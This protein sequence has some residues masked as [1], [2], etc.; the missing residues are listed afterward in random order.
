LIMYKL[1]EFRVIEKLPRGCAVA[2]GNFDG[3]HRGHQRLFELAG[4]KGHKKAAWTFR[5]LAKPG[6]FV[7]CLTDM[8]EKL[9]LFAEY[10]LDYAVFED[11]EAVRGLEYQTFAKEYLVKELSPDRVVC[12]F[13]FRFGRGGAGNAQ[14]LRDILSDTG[15]EVDILQPVFR[16]GKTVSSSAVRDAVLKGDMEEALEI[17]GHPFFI[18]APVCH[19][20]ELGRKLGVPTINQNFPEGHIIPRRGI[21]ACTASFDGKKYAAV[22]NVG[23]RPT[24]SGEAVNCETH[25][26]DFDGDLYGKEVKV[27]FYR[28]I[29]DEMRFE[30]VESLAEQIKRDIEGAREFL[31]AYG[32]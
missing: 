16:N 2:L 24:V 1:P 19:G 20:K 30:T 6:A 17:L 31:R 23:V 10:G 9:E 15:V 29:R 27:E 13:N 7:P 21:Y 28:L 3:V 4:K 32:G 11:F 12:G 8:R 25:I 26:M 18:S 5:E 22:A 14:A